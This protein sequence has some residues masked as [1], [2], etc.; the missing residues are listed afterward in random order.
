MYDLVVVLYCGFGLACLVLLFYFV[1]ASV[2]VCVWF[3]F[4]W[5]LFAVFCSG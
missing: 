5:L 1:F 2:V 3:V 4:G